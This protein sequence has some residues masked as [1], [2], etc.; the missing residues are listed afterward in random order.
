M[1]PVGGSFPQGNLGSGGGGGGDRATFSPG[2]AA[3]AA[4]VLVSAYVGITTTLALDSVEYCQTAGGKGGD[5]NLV[6]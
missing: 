1:E 4:A 6:I 3:Q 5:A 2:L